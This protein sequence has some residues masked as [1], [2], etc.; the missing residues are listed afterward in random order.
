MKPAFAGKHVHLMSHFVKTEHGQFM[1][2]SYWETNTAFA[3]H[4]TYLAAVAAASAGIAALWAP[5]APV[6]NQFIGTKSIQY[7]GGTELDVFAADGEPGTITDS[8]GVLGMPD[9]V[10]LLVQRRTANQERHKMGR[11]YVP[12]LAEAVND[13]G[14][15]TDD[16]Y[17][18]AQ[19]LATYFGSTQTWDA[20]EFNAR[21]WD[22][23][24]PD[25]TVVTHCRAMRKLVIR[26]NRVPKFQ[27][28]PVSV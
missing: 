26:Q 6:G 16:M 3:S 15:V 5:L 22:R 4:V 10:A 2:Q 27:N 25:L 1:W 19:D 14:Y 12:G 24:T 11:F 7:S 17:D 21:H 20:I 18:E 13:A 28:L 23:K 8:T 9:S